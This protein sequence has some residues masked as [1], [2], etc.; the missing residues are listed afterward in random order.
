MPN[1]IEDRRSDVLFVDGSLEDLLPQESPARAIWASLAALD[2]SWL[3]AHYRNDVVGRR[4]IDPRGLAG[5]WILALL[6]GVQSSVQLARLCAQDVEFRWMLGDAPVEKSTLCEFR[7][8]SMDGLREISTQ[9]LAALARSGLLPGESVAL[10][11]TIIRAAASCRSTSSRRTLRKQVARLDE[12][13][14]EALSAGEPE[15]EAIAPLQ[16]RRARLCQA[17]DEMSALGKTRE[18]DTMTWTEP[19]ASRKRLKSGGTGPAHNVQVVTDAA[20]GAIIHTDVVQQ[21]N[22]QGLLLSQIEQA[23]AELARVNEHLAESDAPVAGPITGV[24][25]DSAYHDTRQLDTLVNEHGMKTAVPARPAYRANGV[26]EE[27]LAARFI[28][29]EASD[30]MR[31]PKGKPL[32]R[33]KPNAEGTAITYQAKALDC[34]A[35]PAKSQCCPRAQEGRSVNRALYEEL[36]EAVACHTHS[37]AGRAQ[38]RARHIISE[39]AFSRLI[40]RLHWRRCQTWGARGAQAEA[41]WRQ[42]TH[43]LMLATQGWKPLIPQSA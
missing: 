29:D 2:F 27:Y 3:D 16:R 39:G 15:P 33:R 18:D 13:I 1:Y 32:R 11:G 5:V 23:Q 12:R 20:T 38:R 19:E 6:R 40:Q 31:C 10:D 21:G 8:R 4:A 43:N 26:S 25:A 9:I 36:L 41:L 42:I 28:Y 35:C 24:S 22:D 34:A 7:T 14:G 37:E 30:T 17:L